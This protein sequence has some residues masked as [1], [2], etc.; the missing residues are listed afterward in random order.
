M[1]S[2]CNGWH[3]VFMLILENSVLSENY[4]VSGRVTMSTL[5]IH[6]CLSVR[7]FVAG[8][9]KFQPKKLQVDF[10]DLYIFEL[11]ERGLQRYE[12]FI[13]NFIISEKI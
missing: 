4:Y 13:L 9:N 11:A 1:T 3:Y 7:L 8:Q 12:K 5:R 2:P 10:R 6:V